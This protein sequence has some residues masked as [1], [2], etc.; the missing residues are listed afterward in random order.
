MY[1]CGPKAWDGIS[2]FM[3]AIKL[4]MPL[5]HKFWQYNMPIGLDY[6]LLITIYERER[7][8]VWDATF[9]RSS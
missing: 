4:A 9:A 6:K 2:P 3:K 8:L 1:T 7:T 5:D